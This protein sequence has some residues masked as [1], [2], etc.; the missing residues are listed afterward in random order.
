[1]LQ[2]S[3]NAKH[4]IYVLCLLKLNVVFPCTK[5][6]MNILKKNQFFFTAYCRK[7]TLTRPRPSEVN[8]YPTNRKFANTLVTDSATE[9]RHSAF[10][11]TWDHSQRSPFKNSQA[12]H[13]IAIWGLHQSG[14]F[15][16]IDPFSNVGNTPNEQLPGDCNGSTQQTNTTTAFMQSEICKTKKEKKK[17]KG[18]SLFV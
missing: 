8:I 12:R 2:L 14:P 17:K 11:A 3:S 13:G 10:N 6:K 1:M 18:A 5:H 9:S 15:S 7:W 4:I 16:L